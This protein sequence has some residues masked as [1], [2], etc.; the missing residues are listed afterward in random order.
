MKIIP[1]LMIIGVLLSASHTSRAVT[2]EAAVA[3]VDITPGPGLPMWGYSLRVATGTMD[4]L[5]ARVLVLKVENTKLA[6]VTL[7]LGRTFGEASIATIRNAARTKDDISYVLLAAS[8]DHSAPVIRTPSSPPAT[9]NWEKGA[10]EKIEHAIDEASGH[11][12]P[13]QIGI[14]YGIAYIGHNRLRVEANGDASFF[15]QN[16]TQIPT[17][18]IDPTVSILRVDALNG[19]PIAILVNYACHPVIFG[20]DNQQ[21]SADYPGVMTRVVE[22]AFDHKPLCMFMQGA[23]GDINAFYSDIPLAQDAVK[24]RDWTGNRLGQ[25]V[26]RVARKIK[27]EPNT[28]PSLDFHEDILTFHFRWDPVKFR[29]AF[30]ASSEI[31]NPEGRQPYYEAYGPLSPGADQHLPVGTILINKQI[32]LMAV[33]GEAFVNFQ[34]DWRN[35]CPVEHCLFAGYANGYNGYFPTIVAATRG[36]YGADGFMTWLQPGAGDAMVDDAVVNVYR[37]LGR[38]GDDPR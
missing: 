17:S 5:F 9:I 24:W 30:D 31:E 29:Q 21:Y 14:G 16:Q 8:H 36:G 1:L 38:F 13:A 10:I 26:I 37:M 32:A 15:G 12:V 2:L 20:S 34:I 6:I 11:V 22:E 25:E 19:S 27:S 3:K 18:P 33:P 7:D 28:N 35:R 23:S 4:P